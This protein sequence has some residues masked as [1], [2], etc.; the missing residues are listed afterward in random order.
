MA[1]CVVS[2]CVPPAHTV[3]S[4]LARAG[5]GLILFAG[6]VGA[7][8][9][10][11]LSDALDRYQR[12]AASGGWAAIPDGPLVRPGET[13]AEQVPALRRRLEAEGALGAASSTGATLDPALAQALGRVQDRYGLADDGVIG[14]KTRAALNVSASERARQIEDA[15]GR[16]RDLEVP[17][18]GRW[19]MVNVPEFRVRAFEDGRETMRMRAVVGADRE[20]WR[21]P[22]FSD[23]I[24]Y[25]EFRPVWNV[26]TSIAVAELL[27][28]GADAL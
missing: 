16:L 13:D 5:L 4:F 17:A 18:S 26:P 23:E 28:K 1:V 11:R 15:L 12:V 8:P 20:G 19:V 10:S 7:T 6:A 24:E 22:L 21:T 2:W 3:T 27:P 14:P 9:S 25:L